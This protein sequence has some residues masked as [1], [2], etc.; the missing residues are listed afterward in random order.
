MEEKL[1]E[2]HD[3]SLDHSKVFLLANQR[4]Q[5]QTDCEKMSQRYKDLEREK[6]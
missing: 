4:D 3:A 5:A 2:N 6:N 1:R